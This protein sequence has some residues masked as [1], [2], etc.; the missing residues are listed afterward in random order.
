MTGMPARRTDGGSGVMA[1]RYQRMTTKLAEAIASLA[2]VLPI[3]H[4][5]TWFGIGWET[6]KQIDKRSLATRLGP[7]DLSNV[8]T[9]AIDEF[10]IQR[11]QRYATVMLEPTT[12]RVLWVGRGCGREDV[13][14]FFELLGSQR[15]ARPSKQW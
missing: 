10:A 9:I 8:R 15:A 3:K 14:P 7:V 5:A 13:R 6:V 4:V 2:Q 1:D 12:R 11:G